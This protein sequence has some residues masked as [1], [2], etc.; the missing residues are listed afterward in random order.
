MI[1]PPRFLALFAALFAAMTLLQPLEQRLRAQQPLDV[2]VLVDMQP[3]MRPADRLFATNM[4]GSPRVNRASFVARL[5]ACLLRNVSV[6][7]NLKTVTP[8]SWAFANL[9]KRLTEQ[10]RADLLDIEKTYATAGAPDAYKAL[11]RVVEAELRKQAPDLRVNLSNCG[12]G[13]NGRTISNTLGY[14]DWEHD[15]V[16]EELVAVPRAMLPFIQD[17][18]R[19]A[20][21]TAGA[22]SKSLLISVDSL[23][24]P[25][26]A[27]VASAQGIADLDA[28]YLQLAASDDRAHVAALVRA[29]GRLPQFGG[30]ID[31]CATRDTEAAVLLGYRSLQLSLLPPALV[32]QINR[33]RS[34]ISYGRNITFESLNDI[35][36]AIT[37]GKQSCQVVVGTAKQIVELRAS[38][39][40]Q[41]R[42]AQLAQY[43]VLLP[44]D[45]VRDRYARGLNQGYENFAQL[46]FARAIGGGGAALAQLRTFGVQSLP[47]YQREAAAMQAS[48][49]TPDVSVTAV[50]TY[51]QDLKDSQRGGV[52]VL[53][54]R[55]A[56]LL[57]ARGERE[58]L[59]TARREARAA[60]VKQYPYE[61]VISCGMNQR[62][63][64]LIACFMADGLTSHIEITNGS[65]YALYQPWEFAKL[66]S[67]TVG[68]GLVIPLSNVFTLDMQNVDERMVLRLVVRETATGRVVYEKAAARFGAIRYTS[69]P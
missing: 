54:Q 64:S 13:P 44:V 22:Y 47:D 3:H 10:K 20:K 1:A 65:A 53:A 40:T 43:G 33:S 36:V 58:A 59:E 9:A 69:S 55:D 28:R 24:A 15:D 42:T 7:E 52:T 61:A 31:Y 14:Q 4:D 46:S 18:P 34:R 39:T 60:Y 17:L 29:A 25:A 41:G 35:F 51:L 5:N 6:P 49:H 19:Y 32:E 45:N 57:K 26:Q 66:G 8:T 21:A 63:Q 68:E 38:L 67:E 37:T 56:R 16:Y 48:G 30:E 12:G 23:R 50:L 11:Q 27:I 2:V 62:H